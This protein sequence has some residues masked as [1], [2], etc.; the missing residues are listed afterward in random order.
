[1]KEIESA[2]VKVVDALFL[3]FAEKIAGDFPLRDAH[4]DVWA[5]FE[6][7][8]LRLVRTSDRLGVVPCCEDERLATAQANS[9]LVGCRKRLLEANGIGRPE[10]PR[11]AGSFVPHGA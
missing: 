2:T 9:Q 3:E 4:E 11:Q 10:P 8:L 1:M 6:S 5:L 7:G